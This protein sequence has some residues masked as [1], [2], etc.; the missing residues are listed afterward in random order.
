[1][2]P[3]YPREAVDIMAVRIIVVSG[4]ESVKLV[5]FSESIQIAVGQ[6]KSKALGTPENRN[7]IIAIA[8]VK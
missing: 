4:K 3:T 5:F 6:R 2:I 1:M 7:D 8:I